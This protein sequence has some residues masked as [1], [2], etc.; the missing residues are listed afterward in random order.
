[1][2]FEKCCNFY[3]NNFKF[4]AVKENYFNVPFNTFRDKGYQIVEQIGG[5]A[6]NVLEKLKLSIY[7]AKRPGLSYHQKKKV[8]IQSSIVKNVL[9]FQID[10]KKVLR[11]RTCSEAKSRKI[12]FNERKITG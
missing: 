11:K 5:F 7:L 3:Q 2:S 6:K 12:W 4:C 10:L 9:K 8:C 1:M